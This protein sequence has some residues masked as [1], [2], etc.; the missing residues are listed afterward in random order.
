[1]RRK[2]PCVL[3]AAVAL[4]LV[5]PA[6]TAAECTSYGDGVTRDAAT[7][8]ADILAAPADWAGKSV[9]IEGEVREVC[10][11]AGCWLE[12]VPEPGAAPLRVKVEDGEIVFPLSTRGRRASAEGTVE[13]DDLT[14]EQYLS[15]QEHLAEERGEAF[16]PATVG[17]GPFQ[18]VQV[19]ASGAE[20]C[21]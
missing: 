15:W 14:R 20:V 12:I 18:W 9:R 7:Q 10:P 4:T 11:K 2:L 5:L 17:E 16:D 19:K 3:A 8:I 6:S 1:M 21:L 13:V